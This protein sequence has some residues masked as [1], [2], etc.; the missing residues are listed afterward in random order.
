MMNWL[1]QP[2]ILK[3]LIQVIQLKKTDS[4]AKNPEIE[5]KIL[6]QNCDTLLL[7]NLTS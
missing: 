1:K 2:T 7:K 6:D 3:I 4:N 5:K